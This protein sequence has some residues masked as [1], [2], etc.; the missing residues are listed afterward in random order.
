MLY[1][2][3]NPLSLILIF[4]ATHNSITVSLVLRIVEHR[5]SVEQVFSVV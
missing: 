3:V 2:I 5:D 4:F 1:E